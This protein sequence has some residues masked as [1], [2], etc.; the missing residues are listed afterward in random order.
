[1]NQLLLKTLAIPTLVDPT[2]FHHSKL[3]TDVTALVCRR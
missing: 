3:E 2:H 1:L